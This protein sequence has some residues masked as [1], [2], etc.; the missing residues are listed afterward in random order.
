MNPSME[1]AR[2]IRALRR[3][4]VLTRFM[5][6]AVRASLFFLGVLVA[7]TGAAWWTGAF[8]PDLAQIPFVLAWPFAAGAAGALLVTLL[9]FPSSERAAALADRVGATNDRLLTA[10][11]FLEKGAPTEFEKLAVAEA[12][13][14]MKGRD[15]RPLVPVRP[16]RETP[17]LAVPLAMLALLWWGAF[18]DAA[19]RARRV[20]EE[21]AVVAATVTQLD[22]IASQLGERANPEREAELRRIA[23]RLRQSAAHL[24]AEAAAGNDARKAALRKLAT[25]EDL[26]RQLRRPE[27]ATPAELQALAGALAKH[28]ST[29]EAGLDIQNDRLADAAKKLA[30]SAKHQTPDTQAAEQTL[31][32]ALDHLAARRDEV[33]RQ[34]EDL[35]RAAAGGGPG[36]VL[37]E[38]AGLLD[39]LQRSGALAKGVAK[40]G[41]PDAARQPMKDADLKKLLGALQDMK[42]LQQDGAGPGATPDGGAEP[43][44]SAIAML[45]FH[46]PDNAPDGEGSI[47][48]PT[49]RPGDERDSGTTA[50]PFGPGSTTPD[51]SRRKEQLSGQLAEG[52]SLA[53]LIPAAA[54]GDE[55]A[56]RRYRELFEAAAANAA[57]AVEQEAIPLG[58]RFL[59]RRYFE[60]IRPAD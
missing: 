38:I 4:M 19:E 55:K 36:E 58:A 10:L 16:P 20:S 6:S 59:I 46:P 29:R 44:E 49:G 18:Q 2:R 22:R 52:E 42:A 5:R 41:R 57:D 26:V 35:Q 17:W 14:W 43:P 13:A 45:D 33:S 24:R 34:V 11:R 21:T 7:L 27:A 25:L 53:A 56:A 23:E 48:A 54:G 37:K 40:P 51:D 28:D 8:K 1:I 31:R 30:D 47:R 3:R 39:E 15:L 60:A 12:A 32:Q 9:R 50:D